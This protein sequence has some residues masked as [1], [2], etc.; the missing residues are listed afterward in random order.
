MNVIRLIMFLA[1]AGFFAAQFVIGFHHVE[2][3]AADVHEFHRLGFHVPHDGDCH[4]DDGDHHDATDCDICLGAPGAAY[5]LD[6][7]SF[8]SEPRS[9]IGAERLAL[10]G[11]LLLESA[12]DLNRSRG[13]PT[14]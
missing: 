5:E 1:A 7:K 4:H 9:L 2:A 6:L 13:P 10:L 3:H 14:L 11:S 12:L 8:A